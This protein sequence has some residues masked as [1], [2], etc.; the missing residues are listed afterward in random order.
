MN[1]R[2]GALVETAIASGLAAVLL[3]ASLGIGRLALE[4]RRAHAVSRYAAE[5]ATSGLAV[6]VVNAEA[7]AF[8]TRL[9]LTAAS[10]TTARFTGLPSASFYRFMTAETRASSTRPP[11]LGGGQWNWTDRSVLEEE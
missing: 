6:D 10:V 5:L 7:A 3:S 4:R 9:A 1:R 2:G 11:F 8:A